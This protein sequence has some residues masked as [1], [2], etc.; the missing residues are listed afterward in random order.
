MPHG[1][2]SRP[3]PDALIPPNGASGVEARRALNPLPPAPR[4]CSI[5]DRIGCACPYHVANL[6]VHSVHCSRRLSPFCAPALSSDHSL[7]TFSVQGSPPPPQATQ[8]WRL[9]S[10]PLGGTVFQLGQGV[11]DPFFTL[12]QEFALLADLNGQ[13]DFADLFNLSLQICLWHLAAD[14]GFARPPRD[15]PRRRLRAWSRECENLCRSRQLAYRRYRADPT[16]VNREIYRVARN[17]FA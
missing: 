6:T 9:L 11:L 13:Q 16:P 1:P 5:L 2:S 17:L 15:Q 8:Q 14:S 12:L 4:Y 10:C 3:W 7:A